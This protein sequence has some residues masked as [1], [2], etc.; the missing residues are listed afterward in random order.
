MPAVFSGYKLPK[1]VSFKA[2]L[3]AEAVKES[4]KVLDSGFHVVDSGFQNTDYIFTEY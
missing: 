1:A 4:K 3:K 2:S